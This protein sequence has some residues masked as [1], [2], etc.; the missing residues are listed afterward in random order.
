MQRREI[1]THVSTLIILMIINNKNWT[2]SLIHYSSSGLSVNCSCTHIETDRYIF[3][4]EGCYDYHHTIHT[5]F[6]PLL[7]S[8]SAARSWMHINENTSNS[9]CCYSNR[10]KRKVISFF[11]CIKISPF[12]YTNSGNS[13][14]GRVCSVVISLHV[15]WIRYL[16]FAWCHCDCIYLYIYVREIHSMRRVV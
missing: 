3:Y 12:S 1:L 15:I 13:K 10:R 2:F 9:Y 5:L 6:S 16:Q 14:A 11:L 8:S 7:F 4:F